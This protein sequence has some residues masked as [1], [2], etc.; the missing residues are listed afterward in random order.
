M[1][2]YAFIGTDKNAG[3]TTAFNFVY[4]ALLKQ[5][6]QEKSICLTATGIAGESGY[7]SPHLHK[8]GIV[9][10]KGTYIITAA[11]HLNRW[12][13]C[14]HILAEL[15]APSAAAPYLLCQMHSDLS[16]VLEGPNTKADMLKIKRVLAAHIPDATILIDGAV[17]R[18][19]LAHPDLC[20]A[21]YFA[22]LLSDNPEQHRKAN[23]LLFPLTLSL[24]PPETAHTI[25]QMSTQ[26][27]SCLLFDENQTRVYQG[28][29]PPFLDAGLTDMCLKYKKKECL[30]YL[31]GAL[32]RSLFAFLSDFKY[33][34]IVLDNFTL[35]QNIIADNRQQKF[36][37][38][39]LLL[40]PVRIQRIFIRQDQSGPLS[41]KND[42]LNIAL[43][44]N[45][46]ISDIYRENIYAV[47]V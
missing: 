27:T 15:N 38:K 7:R 25:F 40:H 46:P 32:S 19:F 28:T 11:Q 21:F 22:V 14:Y 20:D 10:Y 12:P 3:K 13:G 16:L 33:F 41:K 6:A 34:T 31:N 43:P 47:N 1:I 37:P 8:P 9:C 23:A 39:L 18:Q 5:G 36:L 2:T 35:Y 30:L 4:Q 24:C 44:E 17:D 45:I 26:Q 42:H 29:R